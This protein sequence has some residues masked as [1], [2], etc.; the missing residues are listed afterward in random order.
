M[1]KKYYPYEYVEDV[2]CIDYKKLYDLGYRGIIFDIDNTLVPH[3]ENSTPK[4]DD[5]M[6]S[7]KSLGLKTLL[8]SDNDMERVERFN[9]N[10]NSMYICDAK[11]PNVECLYKA[12]DKLDMEKDKII[13]IGDQLF[14]D[15]C[16][17]NKIKMPNILVKYIGYYDEGPKGKK[18]AVESIILNFYKKSKKYQHRIG[19]NILKENSNVI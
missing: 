2:F 10:I 8:L 5:F 7:L 9:K 18:R 1:L 19:S 4:V 14:K 6:N 17:A 12:V 3:G 16:L 15:I 11:K 13:Y